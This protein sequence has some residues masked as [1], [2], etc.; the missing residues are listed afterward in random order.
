MFLTALFQGKHQNVCLSSIFFFSMSQQS[1]DTYLQVFTNT[2]GAY[3]RDF[4]CLVLPKTLCFTKKKHLSTDILYF[5]WIWAPTSSTV[6][7]V[8]GFS[9]YRNRKVVR[10]TLNIIY[11]PSLL[12]AWWDTQYKSHAS[13]ASA[14]DW[15]VLMMSILIW[16]R[17]SADSIIQWFLP[18]PIS[19]PVMTTCW[20]QAG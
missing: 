1:I 14:K 2:R 6:I 9:A 20:E 7:T 11:K 8:N 12:T 10:N 13:F 16:W 19:L 3:S 17:Q 4:D 15:P 5:I 18:A